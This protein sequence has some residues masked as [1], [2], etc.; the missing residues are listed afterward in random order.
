M[1]KL[2]LDIQKPYK[3]VKGSP[4]K[5]VFL[6]RVNRFVALCRVGSD[7]V[8]AHLPN[9]GRLWELLYE[10]SELILE[11]SS[12]VN[13]STSYTVVA[14]KT[15]KGPVMLHTHRV[16]SAVAW[17]VG[18][19]KLFGFEDHRLVGRE[20]TYG[21]HRFDLLMDGPQGKVLVEVKSCTFFGE[22]L[23]MFPDAPSVRA[24]KHVRHLGELS[25]QGIKTAVVFAVQVPQPK[26]FLP[27][28]HTDYDFA[29]A[30]LAER[31][32][33]RFSP[34]ALKWS[35]ESLK[36]SECSSGIEIPW[37][38]LEEGC[39]DAGSYVAIF[40]ARGSKSF[41][42][43]GFYCVAKNARKGLN[44]AV[45]RVNRKACV[46]HTALGTMGDNLKVVGVL[47]IRGKERMPHLEESLASIGI[48]IPEHKEGGEGRLVYFPNNPL[49]NKAF[50]DL[51]LKYRVERLEERIL[52]LNTP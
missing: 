13:R 51:L 12:S 52:S 50:I 21:E 31:E 25:R 27:D 8:K 35:E 30:V 7:V 47:P 20:V 28:F 1:V 15:S 23:A 26:F 18:R 4:V 37:K 19:G 11:K 34:V 32:H 40:E 38:L 5:A 43:D 42:K 17:L 44:S 10:N 6:K 39:V 22:L 41:L 9:P 3:A 33:V 36:L 48:P 49:R 29:K 46:P 14:V 2:S 16:N 24:V 45:A